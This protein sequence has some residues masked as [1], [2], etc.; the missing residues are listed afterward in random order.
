MYLHFKYLKCLVKVGYWHAWSK[1]C[2]SFEKNPISVYSQFFHT[3]PAGKAEPSPV[4]EH[5]GEHQG[6]VQVIMDYHEAMGKAFRVQDL[7]LFLGVSAKKG[8]L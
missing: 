7:F 1:G 8:V 4:V 3:F 2:W 6:P 5:D